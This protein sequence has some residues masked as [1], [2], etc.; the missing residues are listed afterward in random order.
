MHR[1]SESGEFAEKRIGGNG[2]ILTLRV[3]KGKGGH[4]LI[5]I[6]SRSIKVTPVKTF[7]QKNQ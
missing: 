2:W 6:Q 1:I 5:E 4:I 7:I 3:I